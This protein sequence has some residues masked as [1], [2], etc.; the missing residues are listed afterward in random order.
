MKGRI[1][2]ENNQKQTHSQKLNKWKEE[3][4]IVLKNI[5]ILIKSKV[6]LVSAVGLC[7]LTSLCYCLRFSLSSGSY[8]LVLEK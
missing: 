4:G 1:K 6:K 2:N 5:Q 8:C 3:R 7:L